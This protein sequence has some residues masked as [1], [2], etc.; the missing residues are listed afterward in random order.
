[1]VCGFRVVH[2]I[3]NVFCMGLAELCCDLWYVVF[4]WPM[5]F[6]M[7]F[8]CDWQSYVVTYGM[9]FSCGPPFQNHSSGGVLRQAN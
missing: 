6:S 9:W 2:A 1:M 7:C 5:Q 4:G 8:A 3:F